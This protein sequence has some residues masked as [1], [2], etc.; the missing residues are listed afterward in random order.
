[1]YSSVSLARAG[2]K[3]STAAR[4]LNDRL[5]RANRGEMPWKYICIAAVPANHVQGFLVVVSTRFD[6]YAHD[7]NRV[8]T[9]KADDVGDGGRLDIP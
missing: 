1:M 2:P 8:T 7:I 6:A 3:G 9:Y 4:R 5:R